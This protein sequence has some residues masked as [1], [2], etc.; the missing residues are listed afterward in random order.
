MRPGGRGC[1]FSWARRGRG[2]DT[3]RSATVRRWDGQEQSGARLWPYSGTPAAT[4]GELR[5]HTLSIVTLHEQGGELPEK[6]QQAQGAQARETASEPRTEPGAPGARDT[7]LREGTEEQGCRG[8]S[9][10]WRRPWVLVR[11]PFPPVPGP[12]YLDRLAGPSDG[13]RAGRA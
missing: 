2:R 1:E 5:G 4:K 3:D 12:E 11:P 8:P 6:A 7:E 10:A 13:A 9:A